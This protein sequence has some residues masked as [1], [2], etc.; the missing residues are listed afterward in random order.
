MGFGLFGFVFM[1][2]CIFLV[3]RLDPVQS[4]TERKR[5]P[6]PAPRLPRVDAP[7]APV[8]RW[9]GG[10]EGRKRLGDANASGRQ[11]RTRA[12]GLRAAGPS[13][14]PSHLPQNRGFPLHRQ[15]GGSAVLCRREAAGAGGACPP[16]PPP[17]PG[18]GGGGVGGRGVG[19]G[20]VQRAP[21]SALRG[22]HARSP[23]R[24]NAKGTGRVLAGWLRGQT[25]ALGL[26]APS[27]SLSPARLC[28]FPSS[29]LWVGASLQVDAHRTP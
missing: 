8:G 2:F 28:R 25:T 16:V 22:R 12:P 1:H 11:V 3:G 29:Q 5:A 20:A 24:P 18:G 10:G 9:G 19:G 15:S 26:G 4:L 23:Q 7:S 14:A 13:G 6:L 17:Q 21:R 27:P